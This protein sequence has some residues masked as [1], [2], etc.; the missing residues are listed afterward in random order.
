M[1]SSDWTR[2]AIGTALFCT[3]TTL[4]VLKIDGA[5]DLITAIKLALTGLGAYHLND[6]SNTP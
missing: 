2:L 1:K 5:G 6:R 4:V 3:W